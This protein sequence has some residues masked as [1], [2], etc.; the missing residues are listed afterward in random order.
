MIRL[1]LFLMILVTTACGA[2]NDPCQIDDGL[3]NYVAQV[4]TWTGDTI[5]LPLVKIGFGDVG[6]AIAMC[7]DLRVGIKGRGYRGIFK[8]ILVNRDQWDGLSD[9]SRL[10]V[11]EHEIVHCLHGVKEHDKTGLMA[12]YLD[13]T[14]DAKTAIIEYYARR[15]SK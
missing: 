13:E 10:M 9:N 3:A 14:L 1:C 5:K 8:Q 6:S 12:A 15:N 4:N 7:K 2:A 11:I